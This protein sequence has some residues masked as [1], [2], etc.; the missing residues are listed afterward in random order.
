M[1]RN[2]HFC[3]ILVRSPKLAASLKLDNLPTAWD[4][5]SGIMSQHSKDEIE[6]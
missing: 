5:P 3:L 6:P 2:G 4:D 1:Q